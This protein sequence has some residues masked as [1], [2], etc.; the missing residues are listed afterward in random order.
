MPW[1][2]MPAAAAAGWSGQGGDP[3]EIQRLNGAGW[4]RGQVLLQGMLP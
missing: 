2:M 1:F 3:A 4:S